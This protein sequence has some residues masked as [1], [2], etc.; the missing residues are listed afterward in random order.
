MRSSEKGFSSVSPRNALTLIA[1]VQDIVTT[2]IF[3]SVLLMETSLL[4]SRV[5]LLMTGARATIGIALNAD[6]IVSPPAPHLRNIEAITAMRYPMIL[7]ATSPPSATVRVILTW[8]PTLS[9]FC[10]IISP[11][12]VGSGR[13]IV[14]VPSQE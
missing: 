1:A 7:P 4:T 5:Q 10:E 3:A 11:I 6:T 13:V 8:L 12:L 2:I 14:S 9:L